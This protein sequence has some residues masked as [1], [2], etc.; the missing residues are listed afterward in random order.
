MDEETA[1]EL[2][3]RQGH[4]LLSVAALGG[5]M[6]SLLGQKFGSDKNPL[7]VAVRSG[8]KFS[9]PGM[10]DTVLNLGLNDRTVEVLAR[11][12]GNPRFAY[13]SYRRFI[14]MFGNVVME[15]SKGDFEHIFDGRKK[16]RKVKMDT[17]L[18][19]DDLKVV[20]SGYKK[21]IRS[22]KKMDFP[23]NPIQ[24]LKMSEEAVF[25]SW[26]FK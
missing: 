8:A 7:L 25:R 12:T 11:K 13:D 23:Q 19:A 5:K 3:R 2:A 20:V 4:G 15:I 9:M 22:K 26:Y 18:T 10:M 24:Q 16:K 6:E 21:L 1:D 17:D 14:Q